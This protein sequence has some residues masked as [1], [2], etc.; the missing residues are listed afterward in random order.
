MKKAKKTSDQ[1][2][3]DTIDALNLFINNLKEYLRE[4]EYEIDYVDREI[5]TKKLRGINLHLDDHRLVIRQDN[6]E[7]MFYLEMKVENLLNQKLMDDYDRL[8]IDSEILRHEEA[9][10]ELK[11]QKANLAQAAFQQIDEDEV[12]S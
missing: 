8:S 12:G 5:Y 10:K 7:V 6:A 11:A 9:L 1:M 3:K 4:G 2:R